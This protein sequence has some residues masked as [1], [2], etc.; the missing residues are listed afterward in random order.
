MQKAS[1]NVGIALLAHCML[2][3]LTTLSMELPTQQLALAPKPTITADL[4]IKRD[5]TRYTGKALIAKVEDMGIKPKGSTLPQTP[6]VPIVMMVDR[7]NGNG[8]HSWEKTPPK[9]IQKYEIKQIK[10]AGRE[11]NTEDYFDLMKKTFCH[12]LPA[13]FL[14]CCN[15]ESV[16]HFT[17]FGYPVV[18]TCRKHP[19]SDDKSFAE[20]FEEQIEQFKAKPNFVADMGN[21]ATERQ[22]L[23]DAKI[24]TKHKHHGRNGFISMEHLFFEKKK[25]LYGSQFNYVTQRQRDVK[26]SYAH[27]STEKIEKEDETSDESSS[28]QEDPQACAIS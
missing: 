14:Y 24:F 20:A 18:A 12:S 19:S 7:E 13:D 22:E 27:A 6:F 17:A 21:F 28:S 16:L 3:T 1:K 8:G 11:I 4:Y 9:A 15:N 10:N 26:P 25:Q 5:K 23:I 2:F